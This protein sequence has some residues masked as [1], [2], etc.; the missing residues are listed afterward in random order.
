MMIAEAP[1][2]P[3]QMEAIPY[4]ALCF[5]STLI[6]VNTILFP[7]TPIGWP[8]AQAPPKTLIL[9]GSIPKSFAFA[10][11]TEANASLISW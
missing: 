2:P 6:K 3:L 4:L 5:L 7:L 11:G 10:I 8:K 1:P 9:Y